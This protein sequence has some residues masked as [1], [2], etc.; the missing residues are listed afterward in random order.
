MK[1]LPE[2]KCF[3]FTRKTGDRVEKHPHALWKDETFH[4][5]GVKDVPVTNS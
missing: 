1:S 5:F 3:Q 2:K 4:T